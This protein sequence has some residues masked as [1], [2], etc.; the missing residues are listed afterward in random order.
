MTVMFLLSN[1]AM[2]IWEVCYALKPH[3]SLV[4]ALIMFS[5]FGLVNVAHWMFSYEYYNMV[6]IIP[7]VLDDIPPP[8]SIFR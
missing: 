5:Y 3:W 1:I 8:G 6:R 4:Y 7:Y 2:V